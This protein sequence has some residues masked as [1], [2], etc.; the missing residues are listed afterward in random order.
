M[1]VMLQEALKKEPVLKIKMAGHDDVLES[2][3]ASATQFCE[4]L[5]IDDPGATPRSWSDT[6]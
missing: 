4:T 2:K 5:L 1:Y 3:S 6:S